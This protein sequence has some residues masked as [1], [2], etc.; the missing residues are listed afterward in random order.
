MGS[1]MPGHSGPPSAFSSANAVGAH[2][3]VAVERLSVA[4]ADDV[5][6]AVAVERVVDLQCRMQRVLGVAQVHAVE[7]VGQ[8]ALDD[9]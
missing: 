3:P 6:H 4:E 8:F 7:V 9:R 5:D 2:E 1:A